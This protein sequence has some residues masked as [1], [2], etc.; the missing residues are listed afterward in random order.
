[1]PDIHCSAEFLKALVE[2]LEDSILAADKFGRIMVCNDRFRAMWNLDDPALLGSDTAAF[3]DS[4]TA[5]LDGCASGK[6]YPED[7]APNTGDG[8]KAAPVVLS[9]KDGRVIEIRTAALFPGAGQD[10]RLWIFRDVTATRQR[11]RYLQDSI[12]QLT[13]II[14]F[15]PEPT[16]IVDKDGIIVVWNKA[17]E[18]VTEVKKEAIVGKGNYEYALPFYNERRPILI[19]W[20][21]DDR[22]P[23]EQYTFVQRKG[24]MLFGEIYTPNAFG[25]KGAYLWGVAAPLKDSSGNIVGA[26]EC[27]RNVTER[28][29]VEQELHRAKLAAEAATRAKSEFLAR[30]SHEIRT[31]MNSILGMSELLEETSLDFDQKNY[32]QTLH[33]SGEMLLAIINDILDFSKIEAGQVDLECVP[34]DLIDLVEG[35]G[36]ILGLKAQEKGLKLTCWV[37]P[38]VHRHVLGDPTRLQQILIN[39]LSNAI[40]FTEHGEVTLH[41]LPGPLPA[42]KETILVTVSDTGIGIPKDKQESV[43]ESFSQADTSTT[44]KFGGTGLGLAISKK[45]IELMDGGIRIESNEG[46]GTTF[47]LTVRL[48][49]TN[50]PPAYDPSDTHVANMLSG[51]KVLVVDHNETN[52]LL[53]HDHLN[54]WGAT[55]AWAEDGPAALAAAYEAEGSGTPYDVIFLDMLMPGMDGMEVAEKLRRLHP[56]AP[57]HIILNTSS[58]TF[59]NRLK[60]KK[61]HLDGLLP[62]PIRRSDLRSLFSKI[63]GRTERH[64]DLAGAR[65]PTGNLDG[66]RLLLVEDIAANRMIIQH[67]LKTTG[68][69]IDEAVNGK[70]AVDTYARAGGQFDIVLMDREMPVMDGLAATRE[71]RAFERG[72]GLPRTPIIALTAHAFVQ[73]KEE[74]LQAGCDAFLSKPVRKSDLVQAI[75]RT[76]PPNLARSGPGTR[77]KNARCAPPP[78]AAVIAERIEVDADLREL[79]PA[80]LDEIDQEMDS[81]ARSIRHGDFEELRRLGHGLKGAAGNYELQALSE[82]YRGLE[83][84][85]KNQ[86][87]A[88]ARAITER[89]NTLRA[90]MEIRFVAK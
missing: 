41:I 69:D 29:M 80:F 42:D 1:M 65:N 13:D 59:E 53:L 62:K 36:R 43:F 21:L 45:L 83:H 84:A 47:L 50:E 33:S 37:A 32:V 18:D 71:I 6:V 9:L 54:R 22:V 38:E 34:F 31:P 90:T 15:L 86:D 26:V 48:K 40:K 27:M 75:E 4:I 82:L 55:V 76:V 30:M 66:M 73:H 63:L 44:R 49:H 24:E 89:I 61:L 5:Q 60:S 88:E 16:M 39:L 17:I 2:A 46:A 10:G 79:M 77:Q 19:D 64:A 56:Q 57:P 35:I 87:A 3:F 68:I 81:I 70:V 20:V 72:R 85:A 11:E 52:R 23:I 28:K 74:S 58:D 51:V 67:Y 14:E 8:E 7:F 25:G 78:P 12:R